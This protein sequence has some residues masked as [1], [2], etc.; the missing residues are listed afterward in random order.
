MENARKKGESNSKYGKGEIGMHEVQRAFYNS[1]QVEEHI[2]ELLVRVDI[3]LACLHAANEVGLVEWA[4]KCEEQ[5]ESY[6]A[7]LI[8][9]EYYPA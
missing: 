9:L 8:A 7:E 6:R 3:Q 4:N 5:L 1:A 2:K